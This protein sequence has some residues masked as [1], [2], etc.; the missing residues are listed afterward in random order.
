VWPKAGSL[1]RSE[2]P[3]ALVDVEEGAGVGVVRGSCRLEPVDGNEVFLLD[4]VAVR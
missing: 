1:G 4:W 3:A 2:Q